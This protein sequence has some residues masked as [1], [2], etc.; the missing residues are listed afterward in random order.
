M[1]IVCFEGRCSN[2]KMASPILFFGDG[3][4]CLHPSYKR[5][6]LSRKD[7][8]LLSTFL[9]RARL[10]LQCE[11][12]KIPLPDR[13]GMPDLAELEALIQEG[14]APLDH[15]C[16]APAMLVIIQLGQFISYYEAR[17][18]EPY[19]SSEVA[20]TVGLCVGQL[21]AIAVSQARSLV[22]LIPL[23]VESVRIA[24]RTG[25]TAT[26]IRD[27]LEQQSSASETW[28]MTVPTEVGYDLLDT[29]HKETATLE[30]KKA[31]VSASFRK[32]VTIQGPPTTLDNIDSWLSS[33]RPKTFRQ[34]LPIYT[35][36]HAPHLYSQE[37]VSKVLEGSEA[38]YSSVE[39]TGT[40]PRLI[41]PVTGKYY[42][43]SSRRSMLESVLYDVLK[44]PI[45]WADVSS[46]CAQYVAAT[47][48]SNWVI[49]P[50]GPTLVAGSLASGLKIEAKV[51][52]A[53]DDFFNPNNP[54]KM[55]TPAREPI[56]IVGMAGRF[57]EAMSHDE[58]W[59]LLEDGIDACK[60]IPA[61]RFD[62][63]IYVS[64]DGPAKN[65]AGTPYGCFMKQPGLFDARL[66]NM[67]P[68]EAEQTDP[69]QR[70]ILTTAYEALEMSGFVPNRTPS[71]QL[72]RI[73][74]YYGQTGDEYREIN[75]AQD[76]QTYY[77][78]GNDRAFGPGRI[79]HYF[80]F[81][82]P[83]MSV[84]TACSSSAVALNVACS[85]IWA[86]DC[87]TALVGG[88]ML[89][90]SPDNFCGLSRGHFLNTT[91]NCKTFDD[92]AD[93]YCR[94]EAV[95]TVV[96][97]RL[98]D[99]K[100][101]ND[102]ILAVILGAGTNYS[103]ASASI[104][105]PHGPTQEVLYKKLLN[106]AGLHPFDID[107]VELHGT[108]TQAG[109]AAEMSSVSNVF[110]PATPQRPVETPLW[111]SSV[112][113]NIGHGESSS[114]VAALIKTLLVLRE[115]KVPKHVG[116]KSGIMNHTFPD[117]EQRRIKV[118]FGGHGSFPRTKE[119]KR[120]AL[121]NNF[122][123]AGGNT[124]L[125]IEEAPEK[126]ATEIVDTRTEHV[127]NVAAK[128]LTSIKN[129]IKNLIEYLE[130]EP[131][132]N[133]SDLSYT[134]TA[135]RMQQPMKVSVTASSVSEL[136]DRLA[137]ALA[138]ESFKQSAKT[139]NIIF[140]FTGQGSLYLPLAKDLYVS[141]QQFQSDIN[142]FNQI[143]LDQGFPS[144]LSV[145][146]G[147]ISDMELLSP[148]QTQLAIC[149]VQMSLYRLWSSWGVNPTAVIG[150]S[151]GEYAALFASGIVSA[152]D[153]LFLVG[154]RACI[155]EATCTQKTHC[156]L[157]I[158]LTM[159]NIEKHLGNR[160]EKL[161]VACIN[162]PEDIV[163]SGAADLVKD[164]QDLL[165]AAGV[166]CTT[167]NTPYAFH[168]AQVDPI[169]N[170]FEA[171]AASV[172]FMKPRIPLL[173]PLLATVIR[174]A[175]V[176]GPSYLRRHAREAVNF[177]QT[178]LQAE[179]ASLANKET[180][181]L[182]LGPNPVNLGMVRSTLGTQ[183]RAMP[184]L[185]KNENAWTTCAKA[186]SFFYTAGVE[187]N[188]NEYHRDF[189]AC[190]N[191]LTLPS[192]AFDEKNYWLEYKNDWLLLK[193]G[194][195]APSRITEIKAEP[196][197]TTSVQRLVSKDVK[198][199]TASLVFETDLSEPHMHNIIAGHSLN[200]LAMCPA[201][202]YADI[203]LTIGD[204][205]RR[206][207]KVNVDT[208]AINVADME[209]LGSIVVPVPRVA[210]PQVLRISATAN[211]DTGRIDLEFGTYAPET[212]KTS[213]K[214]HC[215]VDYGSEKGWLQQW[216]KS[217]WL[218]QKRIDELER[219]V[220]N[221]T[222][223]KITKKMAYQLFSSLVVYGTQYQ[224]MQE[225]LIDAEELEATATLK[226]CQDTN[227]GD[228]FASPLWIDNLAQ[229]SGFVM[230][231][232]GIVDPKVAVYISHGW[233]S[234]QVVGP[235]DAN[236]PYR[237]HVKMQ[238]LDKSIMAGDV[239]VF[240]GETVIGVL[241]DVKFQRVPKSLLD[242]MLGGSPKAAHSNV[243]AIA[244]AAPATKK[245]PAPKA[246]PK[247]APK[248]APVQNS[249]MTKILELMAEE[250]GIPAAE[251]TDD[252]VFEEMGVDS[253][254]SLTILSKIREALG[255]D[256]SP[257][258]FQECQTVGD[259]RRSL[260]DASDSSSS[261]N[262]SSS[263]D[264][265][266]IVSETSLESG[267]QTPA[268]IDEPCTNNAMVDVL[269]AVIAEEVGV[270]VEELIAIDDLSSLG[271]DSL[272][273]LTIV[274]ALRE[275]LGM[276]IPSSL[277]EECTSL[278][279]MK[280]SLNLGPS[281]E[282]AA[283]PISSPKKSV[284]NSMLLQGQP[285]TT[286]QTLFLFPDGSGSATS[287]ASL[288]LISPSTSIIAINSPF[289]KTPD[290]YTV[291]LESA[292]ALMVTELQARQPHG[293]YLL[294]GWS[295]GGMYA[296]EAARLLISQG[297]TVSKLILIDSPCR[298]DY[299]PMPHDVLEYVSKSGVISGQATGTAPQWLVDHF[300]G[301]I[302][303]VREYTPKPFEEGKGPEQTF[304][305]WAKKGVFEDW[306]KAELAGLDLTDAVASWLLKPK[307]DPGSQGWE[308]LLG[309]GIRCVSVEGN[310]FSMVHPPNC[311]S[312][313]RAIGDALEDDEGKRVGKWRIA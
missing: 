246:A 222:V 143:C 204:Y 44:E 248:R 17:P 101:D 1:P 136:K 19:P 217:A 70:L 254:L 291:S 22:E 113:A 215:H 306:P 244:A 56:A 14:S 297:E 138:S 303:A 49:R 168:S 126:A 260:G 55:A 150:H 86:N 162:G 148:A 146:D 88:M 83:S 129:N 238:P 159:A 224:G 258:T 218:V 202:V 262:S 172:K 261:S 263:D 189:A 207:L 221:G 219:G 10:V 6:L 69:Q 155:L 201:G 158:H 269:H 18:E 242:T 295:A 211:L 64:K 226:L 109:D 287:Y 179:S 74:T 98:S 107:F 213:A 301:T 283:K 183:V 27:E 82:G 151:L 161:E 233:G 48:I 267:I 131:A 160:L 29:I 195:A 231:A 165:K 61:D 245:A 225:V 121:V 134:T 236:K 127:I 5:L 35:P 145:I 45:Q 110:A 310:H 232:I 50:F 67:S 36:Y 30:R 187:V 3:S 71:T 256:L 120:R 34:R 39:W 208:S 80:K 209:I 115:E 53:I 279:S 130:K 192:Y 252:S 114:G 72:E 307:T 112:K 259:L 99:A 8:S 251:M 144:F 275:K 170:D 272:M 105:H 103:A 169:L 13:K 305:V 141:S 100:A 38:I 292:S 290:T 196:A 184:S 139:S 280:E 210:T 286:S 175:S 180:V 185:R 313:S 77:I 4:L 76:I 119:R 43:D 240:Q 128:T 91:G 312:L 122:G 149:A 57:P 75:A 118:A 298:T 42:S 94:G 157:S 284:A 176:V 54:D 123:A 271:V 300:Q 81:G 223:D 206:E 97:K 302:R 89:L 304:C 23:A 102:N 125:L 167:L 156:M 289:L 250:I 198:G 197:I 111:L 249:P 228:F 265:Y 52:A 135:R 294:A 234:M 285:T 171:A 191:L 73:G 46:G 79:N 203:A 68:R 182:E 40:A 296:Y 230:N 147:S 194:A 288:P 237:V 24:F 31:Y 186:M 20:I 311:K 37:N 177:H 9:T 299:G 62:A 16:L 116:I 309:R 153:T 104:T 84:D 281:P 59:K 12:T 132:T 239:T 276:D 154:L 90:T 241:G 188:F 227:V 173:S 166:K 152:N 243:K 32:A 255:M 268:L 163:L 124:A 58:L 174:D 2:T 247:L 277:L 212:N 41:S 26:I 78:S 137:A 178:L 7:D 33:N 273:S 108:G 229:L 193:D 282:P 235:L 87:S 47:S 140:T 51:E 117:F 85:A 181:W 92:K 216:S 220:N 278:K 60:V 15:Q 266:D 214:A 95:A 65:P 133:L 270:D 199:S 106:E 21:S 308:K 200:G 253:L 264:D 66:F 190:Q 28:A 25:M 142:R 11:M 164:A 63:D 93:G 205:I 257:S 274:A 293:P 96:I